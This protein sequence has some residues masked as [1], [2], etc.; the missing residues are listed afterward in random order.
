ML[1]RNTGIDEDDEQRD[2]SFLARAESSESLREGQQERTSEV[3]EQA[4]QGQD[5][6]TGM[7]TREAEEA[8]DGQVGVCR[9]GDVE[10]HR[11][12]RNNAS[13]DD[14]LAAAAEPG[15]D[16]EDMG[17]PRIIR[18]IPPPPVNQSSRPTGPSLSPPLQR[19]LKDDQETRAV[20]PDIPPRPVPPPS[21]RSGMSTRSAVVVWRRA[22]VSVPV[23]N[24]AGGSAS[25]APR[26]SIPPPRIVEPSPTDVAP[27]TSLAGSPPPLAPRP[28]SPPVITTMFAQQ[29][30]PQSDGGAAA[31]EHQGMSSLLRVQSN[32][33]PVL[34]TCTRHT[35]SARQTCASEPEDDEAARRRAIAERMTRL[36][37]IRFGAPLSMHHLTRPPMPP[38]PPPT[39]IPPDYDDDDVDAQRE[40]VQNGDEE[41]ESEAARKERIVA[42]IA[43][44]GGTNFGMF[45][46][47][48]PPARRLASTQE[49]NESEDGMSPVPVPTP[50]Q[51][52]P[53]KRKP[54]PPAKPGPETEQE[55]E[56][57]GRRTSD[58][59]ARVEDEESEVV[60]VQYSDVD[61]RSVSASEGETPS[62]PTTMAR[63]PDVLPTPPPRSPPVG[64]P[65]V[66]MVPASL[67][68]RRAS[69][70]SGSSRKS[71]VDC[72]S[73]METPLVASQT[74]LPPQSDY[75]I[76]EA[77]QDIEE[78]RAP[79]SRRS[80]R[81]P[82]RSIPLPPPPPPSAVEPPEVLTNSMQWELPSIPQRAELVA[83]SDI[84]SS[85]W[86]DDSTAVYV[87]PQSPLPVLSPSASRR[88][89]RAAPS[90]GSAED[91]LSQ[92]HRALSSE[93]LMKVWG[94]VGVQIAEAAAGV[95]EK[96]KRTLVGDGT[97]AG[98]VHAVLAQ[99]SQAERSD[100]ESEEWGYV[101]YAQEGTTVQRRVVEIM[102]GDVISFS[103]GRLKG[104]KG[105]HP[106]S[107]SVGVGEGGPLVGV[108]SEVETKKSKVRVW[109]ANRD[110]GQQVSLFQR[111]RRKRHRGLMMPVATQS[112]ELVSYRLE[113]L[114][115][116]HVK[117]RLSGVVFDRRLTGWT[118][119][120]DSG[121]TDVISRFRFLTRFCDHP[122]IVSFIG[123]VS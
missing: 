47:A 115:S 2:S 48:F 79:P 12:G 66:P 31:D 89:G 22:H 103:E 71:S 100:K 120:P 67:L 110:V 117:V 81:P 14:D 88:P 112:V 84:A 7:V 5:E 51:R 34:T 62:R 57:D 43:G 25:V 35:A 39:S 123:V 99:V 106:Y 59:S 98:L 107:Q 63:P 77:E 20:S 87:H 18:P 19:T 8:A 41:E 93:D 37:G 116:G 92:R 122:G 33:P 94:K 69:T 72:S 73:A 90:T 86:S 61:V 6:I 49:D 114:K 27:T 83:D 26:R 101:V 28:T 42:G 70:T 46:V 11:R 97:Y 82:P 36:G 96:S 53:P 24:V 68:N 3:D 21:I 119:V 104:Y 32:S 108:V 113:D 64:R 91:P 76:V 78:T 80:T 40:D 4:C 30:E 55:T 1:Y 74:S 105:L 17:S 118:G 54:P 38:A 9:T 65:P 121:E 75:V 102:P 44:R 60:E 16:G 52:A 15:D 50:P 29:Q 23:R 111:L 95:F 58:D 10:D 13:A 45:P 109:Q 85:G 56:Q